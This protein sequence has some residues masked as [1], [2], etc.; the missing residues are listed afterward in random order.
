MP[1]GFLA[2]RVGLGALYNV[3][4]ESRGRASPR[5]IATAYE[6][7]PRQVALPFLTCHPSLFA[8][9]KVWT[10]GHAEENAGA[11]NLQLSDTDVALIDAVFSRGPSRARCRSCKHRKS[12]QGPPLAAAAPQQGIG[13]RGP[14]AARRVDFERDGSIVLP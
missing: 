6:A 4:V 10:P 5:K 2:A 11:G 9:P 3:R 8:I 7:T 12:H 14:G 13:C 1:S